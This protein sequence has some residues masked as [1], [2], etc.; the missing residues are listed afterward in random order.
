MISEAEF[1]QLF[2]THFDA[3]RTFIFYTD[4]ASD[5]AQ[6]VFMKVWEKRKQLNNDNLKSLLYKMA[7]DL[8]ISN[9]RKN[10]SRSDF[11]QSM[12]LRDGSEAASP[13][14]E[15]L[16]EELASSYVRRWRRCPKRSGRSS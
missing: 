1:K 9:Y 6:D 14:D 7:N 3:I 2:D 13:E 5:M 11:E 12:S 4:T 16:F 15:L 10:T 8:V